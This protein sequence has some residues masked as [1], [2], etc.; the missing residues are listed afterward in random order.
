MR[1]GRGTGKGG[2]EGGHTQRGRAS[3]EKGG[4]IIVGLAQHGL[5]V[6][7]HEKLDH[8][9][10]ILVARQGEPGVALPHTQTHIHTYTA[11]AYLTHTHTC[12]HLY[13]HCDTHD[14][15]IHA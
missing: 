9:Q 3:R 12:A 10:V 4:T 8:F 15:H 6:R 2:K 11:D 1:G 7:G 5:G 13:S 14:T